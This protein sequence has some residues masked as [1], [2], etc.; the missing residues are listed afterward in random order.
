MLNNF[1]PIGLLALS[2]LML[3]GC[4]KGDPEQATRTEAASGTSPHAEEGHEE[5][6]HGGGDEHA[7][8]EEHDEHGHAENAVEMSLETQRRTG[9]K[10]VTATTSPVE[11]YLETTGE[12]TANKDREAHV[13]TRTPGR[14]TNVART[15]GDTVQA[16]GVLA[17]LESTE[18]GQAQSNYLDALARHDLVLQTAERQRRLFKSDLIARKEVL[19]AENELRLA[20]IALNNAA[21]QLTLLGVSPER[22]ATLARKRQLDP[23]VPLQSPIAGVVIARHATIGE[24]IQPEEE[25]PAFVVSDISE[26]W[27]NASLYERDLALVH[28]GQRAVVT[29]PAYPGRSFSGRVSL[30]STM[31]EEQTRTAKARIVV[32]NRDLRLKPEMFANIKI[33]VGNRPTLA[34]PSSAVMQE[35]GETFVFVKESDTRF[36]RRPVQVGAPTGGLVPVETGLK[37]GETVVS[38][39]AFTLKAELLKES[40]G[41]HEH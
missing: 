5:K 27:V 4:P 39:G 20:K 19:A 9:L 6:G 22:I 31:L 16:G 21:N 17:T 34:I 1:K 29:T 38:D 13:T 7:E 18:L 30:I 11:T 24:L 15:V 36:E 25:Q 14:I 3:A 28:E 41:E 12:F 26:L 23:T 8:G 2:A 32:D 35:K 37:E 40:F 10:T 33:A